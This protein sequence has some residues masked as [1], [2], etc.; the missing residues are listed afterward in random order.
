MGIGWCD[1][2]EAN[3]IKCREAVFDFAQ[4]IFVEEKTGKRNF[5]RVIGLAGPGSRFQLDFR[6]RSD[7]VRVLGSHLAEVAIRKSHDRQ[8]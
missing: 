6:V 8:G 1:R 3:T 7:L 5:W 2:G 4:A